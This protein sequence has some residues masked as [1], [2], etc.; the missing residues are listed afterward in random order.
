MPTYAQSPI[1]LLVIDP[2]NSFCH[3]EK[4]ELYVPGAEKDMDRMAQFIKEW[5]TKISMIH[6]TLDSHHELDVA[7][8]LFWK[9]T[10]GK[11]PEPFTVIS[12]EDVENG[13]WEPYNPEMPS[14]PYGTLRNRMLH[15]VTELEK[16]ERYQLLIWPPHCL[17]GTTGHNIYSSLRE[18]L[19]DWER[20]NY[21]Y[22]NYIFKG[23]NIYTENYSGVQADVPDPE[24]PSTQL[25]EKL[26]QTLSSAD[27]ILIA[28]EAAS[29]CVANTV[30]DLAKNFE[31]DTIK[32]CVLLKDGMSPVKGFEDF[33]DQFFRDM[34]A[35]G[36]RITTT[37]EFSA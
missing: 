3:P 15:Y 2:Q 5:L 35:K 9:D 24:D 14:P 13:K 25:N 6:V 22:I 10:Q 1:H 29:H 36:M 20:E 16:G 32:K 27:T 17:I 26:I 19:S 12:K 31:E 7:H 11:H 30:R 37:K 18:A 21:R 34:E 33:A 23:S 8:P 28:G 4:G